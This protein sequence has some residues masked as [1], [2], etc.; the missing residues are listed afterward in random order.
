LKPLGGWFNSPAET[1][2][3]ARRK[4]ERNRIVFIVTIVVERSDDALPSPDCKPFW[5]TLVI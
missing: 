5:S 1:V 4:N 3:A 2:N